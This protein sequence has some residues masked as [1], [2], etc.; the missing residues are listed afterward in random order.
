MENDALSRIQH[1]MS[2]RQMPQSMTDTPNTDCYDFNEL[3]NAEVI[4]VSKK[5]CYIHV[6]QPGLIGSYMAGKG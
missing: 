4:P 1:K 5:Y 6:D 2:E 3:K